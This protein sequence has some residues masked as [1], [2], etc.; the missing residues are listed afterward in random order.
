MWQ[1]NISIAVVE[2]KTSFG[3]SMAT[4]AIV[5]SSFFWGYICSQVV[6]ALLAQ[7]YGGKAV[8]GAAGTVILWH[9]WTIHNGS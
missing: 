4:Q 8:L 5:L 6:G 1:V 7:R 9:G 3:W 2:M